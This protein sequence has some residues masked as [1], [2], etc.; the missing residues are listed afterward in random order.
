[1]DDSADAV[2]D[3]TAVASV[4]QRP[5]YGTRAAQ[6]D[7]GSYINSKRIKLR[8]Q[9]QQQTQAPS[10]MNFSPLTASVPS[11]TPSLPSPSPSSLFSGLVF[12]V[13][14]LTSPPSH[15]LLPLIYLHAGSVENVLVALVTHCVAD[16]VPTTKVREWKEKSRRKRW[17]VMASWVVDCV[18]EG[19]RLPEN[20]Y[21]PPELREKGVVSVRAALTRGPSTEPE[22]EQPDSGN[23]DRT[24][25]ASSDLPLTS[26]THS[27]DAAPPTTATLPSGVDAQLTVAPTSSATPSEAAA[28]PPT[29]RLS[30]ERDGAQPGVI[31]TMAGSC[32]SASAVLP[33][34]PTTSMSS[35]ALAPSVTAAFTAPSPLSFRSLSSRPPLSIPPLPAPPLPDYLKELPSRPSQALA[36]PTM[37]STSPLPAPAPPPLATPTHPYAPPPARTALVPGSSS[38]PSS[39][40]GSAVTFPPHPTSASPAPRASATES[41]ADSGASKQSPSTT[42]T[43]QHEELSA[44]A[45]SS[46]AAV[47]A[48]ISPPSMLLPA[49][50]AGGSA[51]LASARLSGRSTLNDPHFVKTF[52]A[53]SRLHF[54][55]SWKRLFQGLIPSLLATPPRVGPSAYTASTPAS[56]TYILHCDLD[57][58]FASIAERDN[59]ALRD[60]PVAVCHA[61]GAADSE[62][63][64]ESFATSVTSTSSISSCNY[65]A[66][67]FGLHAEMSIGRARR[68]CPELVLVPYEFTKYAEASEAIYRVFFSVTHRI[69]PVS[70][71]EC[72]MELPAPWKLSEVEDLVRDV[73]RRVDAATGVHVSVGISHSLLLARL[74]T[75]AAKPNNLHFLPTSST[76]ALQTYMAGLSVS[77]IP[78]IGWAAQER[79]REELKVTTCGQLQAVSRDRLQTLFGPKQ[80]LTIFD[81]CRG[82]DRRPLTPV[83]TGDGRDSTTQQSVA[84]N[85]NYGIRFDRDEQVR[86]FLH[87]LSVELLD[88]LASTTLTAHILSMKLMVRSPTAP[89]EPPKKFLGHGVCDTRNRSKSVEGRGLGEGGATDAERERMAAI[90]LELWG[91]LTAEWRFKVE[92]LRGV[93]LQLGRLKP[94]QMGAKSGPF[95]SWKISAA[96]EEKREEREDSRDDQEPGDTWTTTDVDDADNDWREDGMEEDME[97]NDA[98]DA[99]V[100]APINDHH[101]EESALAPT[102]TATANSDR[103]DPALP[104]IVPGASDAG[105][106]GTSSTQSVAT[107]SPAV[108]AGSPTST[109]FPSVAG[110]PVVLPVSLPVAGV[111]G[112]TPSFVVHASSMSNS[113][114]GSAGPLGTATVQLSMEQLLHM[115]SAFSQQQHLKP[116][117][118]PAFAPLSAVQPTQTLTASVT[119]PASIAPSESPLAAVSAASHAINVASTSSPPPSSSSPSLDRVVAEVSAE[120]ERAF[121]ESLP[122]FTSLDRAVIAALP[123]ELRQE[124]ANAYKRKRALEREA[125]EQ[126]APNPQQQQQRGAAAPA[127]A[128]PRTAAPPRSSPSSSSPAVVDVPRF[129]QLDPTVLAALPADIREEVEREYR[130]RER[131]T[132]ATT[133]AAARKPARAAKKPNKRAKIDKR[134]VE[135]PTVAPPRSHS[136]LPGVFIVNHFSAFDHERKQQQQQQQQHDHRWA[137]QRNAL[138]VE[139][140][141]ASRRP[142]RAASPAPSQHST[143]VDAEEKYNDDSQ[144]PAGFTDRQRMAREEKEAEHRRR[145]ALQRQEEAE[146]LRQQ[147]TVRSKAP[148]R[149]SEFASTRALHSKLSSLRPPPAPPSSAPPVA[150]DG[151]VSAENLAAALAAAESTFLSF[152]S[153]EPHFS[154]WLRALRHSAPHVHPAPLLS[155]SCCRHAAGKGCACSPH[156]VCSSSLPHRSLQ[157]LL[158]SQLRVRNVECVS[159]MLKAMRTA[160]EEVTTDRQDTQT[161]HTSELDC[162]CF[163]CSVGELVRHATNAVAAEYGGVVKPSR[164]V[165]E[166]TSVCG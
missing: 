109:S 96:P 141:R 30:E 152:S 9:F 54:I 98:D 27:A 24:A 157:R 38:A 31:Q 63:S 44:P 97:M 10:P 126:G 11:P 100:A 124:L 45:L 50:M 4:V 148:L 59:P 153:I 56:P 138:V 106:A 33:Q 154:L 166:R 101:T 140:T 86:V 112:S 122:P 105:S 95:S 111:A 160:A 40:S 108:S 46:P 25:T 92:D 147:Q 119:P 85:I 71:D 130:L 73:R 146:R 66:R 69:Q 19:R 26:N 94:R 135:R 129:S 36:R 110:V 118:T 52:F 29:S 121:L 49:H 12:W 43:A 165:L 125:V 128:G 68:M 143:E 62:W 113:A 137:A 162:L 139:E 82:V 35:A 13:N 161:S 116:Q 47:S 136:P 132:A 20:A 76:V 149:V 123:L 155:N 23:A 114:F 102:T 18:R 104:T 67:S 57:C 120:K 55:G 61:R 144:Q 127:A 81:S 21:L 91:K 72:Y 163:R 145:E 134:T 51:G 16:H 6:L 93:G 88:R 103:P 99:V 164:G 79:L 34:S 77:D 83:S 65:L 22:V 60:K 142:L 64:P 39:A 28:V 151:G 48:L 74:A 131:G 2:V 117:S 159:A 42:P 89:I 41:A 8:H 150:P 15:H 70:L 37:S 58:F 158:M 78:G 84:V 7:I 107:M 3:L 133:R 14:G 90:V 1:M 75:K 115:L 87:D 53:A 156:C 32:S 5:L 17:I 80:G